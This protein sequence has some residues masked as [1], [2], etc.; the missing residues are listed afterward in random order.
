MLDEVG[1]TEPLFTYLRYNADI[2]QAGL[3]DRGLAHIRAKDVGELDSTDHISELS[4]IGRSV[5]DEV[6]EAHFADF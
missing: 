3:D 4:E 2:S 6:S 5:A 1:P